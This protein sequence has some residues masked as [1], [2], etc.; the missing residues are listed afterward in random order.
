LLNIAR[1]R[2]YF[3]H[4]RDGSS[5]LFDVRHKHMFSLRN[6]RPINN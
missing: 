1:L 6:P 3:L 5:S 4:G 2:K